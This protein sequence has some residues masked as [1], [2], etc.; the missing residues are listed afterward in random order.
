MSA[1][2]SDPA[3]RLAAFPTDCVIA[4]LSLGR[5]HAASEGF[6]AHSGAQAL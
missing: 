6:S 1:V 3:I 2:Q 5:L 4:F